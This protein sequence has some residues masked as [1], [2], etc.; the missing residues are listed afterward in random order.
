MKCREGRYPEGY[1]LNDFICMCNR[2]YTGKMYENDI[3]NCAKVDC[4]DRTCTWM[5][6]CNCFSGYTGTKY[7]IGWSSSN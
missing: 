3:D 4:N 1:L 7:S 2:E 6:H 5:T